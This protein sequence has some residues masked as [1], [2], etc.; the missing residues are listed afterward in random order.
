MRQCSVVNRVMRNKLSGEIAVNILGISGTILMQIG[1]TIY[2]ENF[3]N[4]PTITKTNKD[5]YRKK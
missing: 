3:Q 2:F 5:K 4:F 1:L